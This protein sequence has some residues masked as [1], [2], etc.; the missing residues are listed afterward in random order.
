MWLARQTATWI[1]VI[2]IDASR[3]AYRFLIKEN[4]PVMSGTPVAQRGTSGGLD[5]DFADSIK[6]CPH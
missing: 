1:E 2:V 5:A 6:R 4:G 3:F